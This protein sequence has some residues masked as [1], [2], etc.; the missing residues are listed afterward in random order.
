MLVGLLVLLGWV[1]DITIFR[2][3]LPGL[4]TMEVNTAMGFLLSGAVLCLLATQADRAGWILCARSGAFILIIFGSMT[5]AQ[6][7]LQLDFGNDQWLAGKILPAGSSGLPGRMAPATALNFILIGLALLLCSA[8][9][10][11]MRRFAPWPVLMAGLI[12]LLAVIGYLYGA[13][14]LYKVSWF[15][16]MALHTA[17]T[18]IVLTAGILLI[19]PDCWPAAIMTG[20]HPGN[21]VARRLLP[22]AFLVTLVLGWLRLAGEHAGLFGL[23]FGLALFAVSNIVVFIV[24]ILWTSISLNRTEAG[25]SQLEEALRASEGQLAN[26]ISMAHLGP[27]EYDVVADRFRFNDLFYLLLRT[28]AAREGGY[29]MS[30][31]DYVKRFVHPDDSATVRREIGQPRE[32]TDSHYEIQTEH[33]VIFGD[34]T[35]GHI[36]VRIFAVKDKNNRSIKI[37]GVNQDIT[38]HKQA[39]E[40]LRLKLAQQ[41]AITR[42]SAYAM[43]HRDVHGVMQQAVDLCALTLNI[44]YCLILEY[45][46]DNSE[47]MLLRAGVGWRAGLAGKAM[48][49]TGGNSHAGYTLRAGEPVLIEDLGTE[50]RFSASPL[51]TEH[52]VTSGL[53]VTIGNREQPLGM[54]GVYSRHRRTFTQQDIEF[55]QSVANVLGGA[56]LRFEIEGT[57]SKTEHRFSH[58]LN[59]SPSVVYAADISADHRC[60]FVSDMLAEITG[61]Q[62]AEMIADPQFWIKHVHPDDI[63]GIMSAAETQ[64]RHGTGSLRYRF[65]HKDGSYRWFRDNFRV[66]QDDQAQRTEMVGAWTDITMH[67]ESTNRILRLNRVYKM[68]SAVNTLIIH[69]NDQQELLQEACRIAVEEGGFRLAWAGLLAPGEKVVV[70]QFR[71]GEAPD[72]LEQVHITLEESDPG[73][74]SVSSQALRSM[75][76]V[77]LNYPDSE[78]T[79]SY[80]PWRE[81][82]MARGFRSFAGLPIVADGKPAGVMALHSETPGFFDA[83]EVKLLTELAGDISYALQNLHKEKK[84]A[85]LVSYDSLTGLANETLFYDHLNAV[86]GRARKNNRKVGLLV[87]DL[88]QFHHINSVYG[89]E[90]GDKVL[91]ETARRLRELTS[92]PVNIGRISSDYFAMI[93]HDVGDATAMAYMLKNVL[94]PSLNKTFSLDQQVIQVNFCGGIAIHPADGN[95]AET[96]YRNAEAAL[97][98]AKQSTEQYLFYQPEMTQHIAEIMQIEHKLRRAMKEEQ[99]VLHYQ[100]KIATQGHQIVGLEALI[101]W[102][103]PESGL[104]PPEKFIPI[105]EQTGLILEVGQWALDRAASDYR[106][107]LR[108]CKSVP[109]IAVNISA[110]QLRQNDFVAQ[111]EKAIRRNGE[112]VPVDLEITESLLMAD[113]EQNIAKLKTIRAAGLGIAVDDFGTG[114][115]SLNYVAKLPIDALKIDRSFIRDMTS[116]PEGMTLVSTIITLA[117]SLHY[118]VIAEGVE[119]EEQARFLTLLQCDQMQGFLFSKPLPAEAMLELLRCGQPL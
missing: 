92:D 13:A 96:L 76:P 49:A 52:D 51:L 39:E 48:V 43:T 5:L 109:R 30:S 107:W 12:S 66:L 21:R 72:F 87:S 89:R 106:H 114:Y 3:V 119:T 71:A 54:L 75:K 88:R 116:H 102:N 95:D 44:E 20:E 104:V 26:A 108:L 8:T 42:F 25:R 46:A 34:G 45:T 1:P 115:S 67:M 70:P 55:I 63:S 65:R 38:E 90:S 16:T 33:R 105:L 77:V 36:A 100:P 7:M 73:G 112:P 31:A 111:V 50:L 78:A 69:V 10:D 113:V 68:L 14:T 53:G 99:F 64:V 59:S 17:L 79:S 61:F 19:Q 2:R 91:Q 37:H 9:S 97:K 60:H 98:K 85:F 80:V 117:H 35:S 81:E 27:W 11:R 28:T 23:E 4:V 118:K 103:D 40:S 6:D 101:R 82:A 24:L 74:Q 18:F 15:T 83:E 62:P 110:I 86:L 58:L 29:T 22:A 84:L 47:E 57:L 41:S 56:L 94:F 32:T 93:L